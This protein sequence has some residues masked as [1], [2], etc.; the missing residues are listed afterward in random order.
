MNDAMI[1]ADGQMIGFTD[2]TMHVLSHSTQRG[3]AVFDV[4]K[5]AHIR[6]DSD[7]R[8][9]HAVGL[10]GHVER[11]VQSMKLMGMDCEYSV[12]E[13]EA[14]VADTVAANPGSVVV[15]LVGAWPEIPLRTLPVTSTPH[16]WIAALAPDPYADAPIGRGAKLQTSSAPKM[17]ASIL[18]PGLK[19]AASYTAGFDDVLSK[20]VDGN[21]AEGTTQSLAVISGSTIPGALVAL[22]PLDV[23]LDSITRRM[24]IEVAQYLGLSVEIRTVAWSEVLEADELFLS[25]SNFSALPVRQLDDHTYPSP[26]P[27]TE[28]LMV[29]AELLLAGKHELSARWLTRL[30]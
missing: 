4:I 27:V 19:V 30:G 5:L 2:A 25:S 12:A 22:P 9:P 26:G 18:P 6:G 20:T 15:K 21:L 8:V 23:V 7:A 11:F 17:P 1:W 29:E 10:N 24:M 14:A 13:L 3:S 28:R 16:V